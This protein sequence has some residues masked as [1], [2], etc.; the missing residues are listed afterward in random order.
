MKLFL[1]AG[2]IGIAA[3]A[4]S[5]QHRPLQ[6]KEVVF[7]AADEPKEEMAAKDFEFMGKQYSVFW[8][9]ADAT[10]KS[11]NWSHGNVVFRFKDDKTIN[12]LL[13]IAAKV[14]SKAFLVT[15]TDETSFPHL[16]APLG[17][18]GWRGDFELRYYDVRMQRLDFDEDKHDRWS[19]TLRIP[20]SQIDLQKLEI[21]AGLKIE[22]SNQLQALID[23]HNQR[24]IKNDKPEP[25]TYRQY[26]DSLNPGTFGSD[27][28]NEDDR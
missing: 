11:F 17:H 1:M 10:E 14:E 28:E 6:I 16:R 25:T 13:S 26:R 9:I 4:M 5:C 15:I 24:E 3:G 7:F 18:D 21:P 20:A 27:K 12:E 19:I 22:Y 23:Y 2:L 8:Q